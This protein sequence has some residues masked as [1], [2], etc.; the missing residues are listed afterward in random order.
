LVSHVR[1]NRGEKGE[2]SKGGAGKRELHPDA[3]VFFMFH[4]LINQHFLYLI[5]SQ[6]STPVIVSDQRGGFLRANLSQ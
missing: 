2:A 3:R 1:T 5:S 4:I 6:P